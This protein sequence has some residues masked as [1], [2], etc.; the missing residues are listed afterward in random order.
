MM[1]LDPKVYFEK[2][3]PVA[4]LTNTLTSGMVEKGNALYSDR[5][6]KKHI[7]V[8]DTALQRFAEHEPGAITDF[9]RSN[10][11][12]EAVKGLNL[13]SAIDYLQS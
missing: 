5:K 8:K 3:K 11:T 7:L 10:L 1:Q 12:V 9:K 13:R 2:P 6:Y 4:V